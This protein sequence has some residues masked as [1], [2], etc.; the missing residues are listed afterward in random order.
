LFERL[1]VFDI[2]AANWPSKNCSL[3]TKI[4]VFIDELGYILRAQRN[5][6]RCPKRKPAQG[7]APTGR[8][9]ISIYSLSYLKRGHGYI[10][11]KAKRRAYFQKE[12]SEWQVVNG[13]IGTRTE[14]YLI[15]LSNLM[16]VLDRNNMNED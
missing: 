1:H 14:H 9:A 16:D 10:D 4:C 5:F 3:L 11:E 15:Y 13:R 8:G 2:P 7:T 12:E 6:G